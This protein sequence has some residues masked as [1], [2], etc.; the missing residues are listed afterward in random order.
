[1]RS[2]TSTDCAVTETCLLNVW[3]VRVGTAPGLVDL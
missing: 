3:G 2:P 1:C